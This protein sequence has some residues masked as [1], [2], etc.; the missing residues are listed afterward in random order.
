MPALGS[1]LRSAS[2]F[3]KF[4]NSN[5]GRMVSIG[6]SGLGFVHEYNENRAEG[7]GIAKSAVKGAGNAFIM[8]AVGM[9]VYFGAMALG[10][11]VKGGGAIASSVAR[12]SREMARSNQAFATSTFVDTQQAYTMRQAG[13]QQ[14]Q[15]S[16]MNTKRALLGN[17]AR[18]M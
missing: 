9:P 14:V 16:E 7:D 6:L 17:E 2:G 15:S 5:K 3:N 8:D 13:M 4:K 11:A 10:G 1:I 12:T 18:Y